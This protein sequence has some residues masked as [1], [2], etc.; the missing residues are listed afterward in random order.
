M[1]R[2]LVSEHDQKDGTQYMYIIILA[3]Y[4]IS[5]QMDIKSEM[6]A[7]SIKPIFWPE[8][9]IYSFPLLSLVFT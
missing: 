4:Q 7:C 8:N 1:N 9:T 6:S 5:I 3:H 2:Y